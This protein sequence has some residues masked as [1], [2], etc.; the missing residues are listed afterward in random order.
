[1]VQQ[2]VGERLDLAAAIDRFGG[3]EAAA[4]EQ[5]VARRAAAADREIAASR[6]TG[7]HT[8]EDVPV[9][10]LESRIRQHVLDGPVMD[11][12]EDE[13][14]ILLGVY[15][16]E[17]GREGREIAAII[18]GEDTQRRALLAD[19]QRHP[20]FQKTAEVVE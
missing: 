7:L 6:P 8:G 12:A 9:D 2:H 18:H 4:L 14:A 10:R 17:L 15:A 11:I 3:G 13:L 16:Q 1:M 20:M 5:L 19:L